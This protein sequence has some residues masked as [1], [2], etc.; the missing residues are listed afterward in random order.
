MLT[1]EQQKFRLGGIGAS[2]CATVL[3]LNPYMSPY[4]LWLEKTEREKPRDLSDNELVF[5][6][7]LLEPFVGQ[8]YEKRTE[9]LLVTGLDPIIHPKYEHIFCT[10]DAKIFGQEKGVEIKT[11][12]PFSNDWGP[13]GTDEIPRNYMCQVQHQLACTGWEEMDLI[14]FRAT[15]D[16]RIYTIKR[17]ETI[18]SEI[19]KRLD[20]FWINHVLANKAPPLIT[21]RDVEYF[22]P[23]NNASYLEA[24]EQMLH[25]ISNIVD[26]RAHI[27]KLEEQKSCLEVELLKKV[28]EADG[29]K[30]LEE[31]L[32]SWKANKNGK[33]VLRINTRKSL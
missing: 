2:D 22:F 25:E 31:N 1:Q 26:I 5:I 17:N 16:I 23:R 14:V 6:G 7:Q 33:R 32:L 20:Y 28:G 4:E 21:L 24:D 15:S 30:Y 11:S 29:V 18:I 3:G 12:N 19:E 10:L 9:K 27:N 8:I 13:A